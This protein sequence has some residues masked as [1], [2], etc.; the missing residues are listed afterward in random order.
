MNTLKKQQNRLALALALTLGAC[1][2][3]NNSNAPEPIAAAPTPKSTAL[4]VDRIAGLGIVSD[5]MV[6]FTDANGKFEYAVGKAITFFLG[7]TDRRLALGEATLPANFAADALVTPRNFQGA[8]ENATYNILSLLQSLDKDSN[9]RNGI[10]L[11]AATRTAFVGAFAS[12][13]T[14]NVNL[15]RAE[16]AAQLQV[17]LTAV[18]RTLIAQ[19]LAQANFSLNFAQARS[20]SVALSSDDRK[21]V[22]VNRQKGTASV[23][24]VRNASGADTQI[25]LGEVAVGREPRFVTIAKDNSR[26]YVTSAIDGTLAA[27]DLRPAVPVLLGTPIDVGLEPRGI[28]ISPTGRYAV[29]ANSTLGAVTLVDLATFTVARRIDTGGNPHAVSISNDGDSEDTDETVYVSRLYSEVID[30]A[31]PDG[32]DDAKQG[33]ID[34]FNLGQAASGNVTMRSLILKPMASGFAADRRNFCLLT[35]QALAAAGTVKYFN[36][37]ADGLGAGASALAKT[38]FCPDN[39]SA[40]I[41]ATGPIA[42]VPQK[43][44]PNML[45]ALLVRGALLYVPNVGASPEPPV[46]FNVNVHGLVGVLDRLVGNEVFSLNLNAQI[47]DEVQPAEGSESLARVFMNDLVAADADQRGENFLFVSRGANYIVRAKRDDAGRL[48]IGAPNTVRLQTGNLPSGVVMSSD[49]KRAY[50]NNELSTS[51]S[52]LDLSANSTLTLDINASTPPAAGTLEHQRLLGKLTFFTALGL[53][54]A[55]LNSTAIRDIVPLRHKGKASDNGWSSCASCHEDG[56]SD[57]VT[58]IFPTGPRSTIALEGS[59]A[60]GNLADQR[61]FNWS[62]VQ[63]SFTDFNNNARG[64][65]GG[66]GFATNVNGADNTS[67][68]FNHGFVTGVSESLDAMNVWATTIRAPIMPDPSNTAGR[69]VFQANCASCH[70]GPK[71]TKSRITPIYRNNATFNADPIGAQFFTAASTNPPLDSNLIVAGPQIRQVNGPA[72]VAP[73]LF[74]DNVGTFNAADALQIRGAGTVGGQLA[75]GFAPF[76]ALGFNSPSLLGF[77]FSGPWLHDGSAETVEE[78]FAKHKL[79]DGRTIEAAI[80]DPFNRA[81]LKQFVLSIDDQTPIME[82]DSDRFLRQT[83]R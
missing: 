72:G 16:F 3:S 27:I 79:P 22:V 46:R 68:A 52:A 61:V 47:K 9:F 77:A 26:A 40:D 4:F 44:Y 60:R 5:S 82:S 10:E 50:S 53:P 43:V 35:R 45:N 6:S 69:E 74:L 64:I 73:L 67:K 81:S 36:S 13:A 2:S 15:P 63:G 49:G 57:N 18:N 8:Q 29:I 14:L 59:F 30:P 11:D 76:G 20:S 66:K 54:D 28:A 37:G 19:E 12:G 48:S 65:Q 75:Q 38:T 21:L 55:G 31:R 78:V 70:G 42:V 23:I 34:A 83:G 25:L 41:S 17:G 51:V 1:S 56:H 39:N 58:W 71:W 33:V 7:S 62:G 32:F 80:V 24:E